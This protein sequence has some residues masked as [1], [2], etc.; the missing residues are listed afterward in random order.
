MSLVRLGQN[1]EWEMLWNMGGRPAH[2]KDK[3]WSPHV[4]KFQ[5]MQPLPIS[6]SS[7]T[8]ALRLSCI[9]A[10]SDAQAP[11][12][13]AKNGAGQMPGQDRASTRNTD[14]VAS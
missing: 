7:H 14:A 12:I 1:R 3:A 10:T 4:S 11:V 9:R 8:V 2:D 13:Q 5:P 6:I